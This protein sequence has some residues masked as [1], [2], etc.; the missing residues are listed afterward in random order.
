MHALS[1]N[2]GEQYAVFAVPCINHEMFEDLEAFEERE[3]DEKEV[4]VRSR[5]AI[6]SSEP[7]LR[8]RLISL[9]TPL[10]LR[11][12]THRSTVWCARIPC[13]C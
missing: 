12:L 9:H 3:I 13:Q 8:N 2:D 6:R 1:T 7:C 4:R 10:H 5:D 11:V